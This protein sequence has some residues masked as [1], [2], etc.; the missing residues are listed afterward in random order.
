MYSL[1]LA[2]FALVAIRIISAQDLSALPACAQDAAS[3]GFAQTGCAFTDY[4]CICNATAFLTSIQSLI[5]QKCS[6]VDQ[7]ATIAFAAL[8]CQ[9][10]GVVLPSALESS[11]PT[12]SAVSTD[13][14]SSGSEG[15]TAL[16]ATSALIVDATTSVSDSVSSSGLSTST[17]ASSTSSAS[18]ASSTSAPIS[19]S[20]TSPALSSPPST[21]S[22]FPT[23]ISSSLSSSTSIVF[24]PS[25]NSTSNTTVATSKPIPFKGDAAV[26]TQSWLGLCVAIAG[27][28]VMGVAL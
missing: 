21:L 27:A 5:E 8:L 1:G 28:A 25:K 12:T 16:A 6:K 7:Q 13:A 24:L 14:S 26:T 3:A 10:A 19:A 23:T 11:A 2:S 20:S 18:S 9:K 17:S 22:T 15:F 4:K